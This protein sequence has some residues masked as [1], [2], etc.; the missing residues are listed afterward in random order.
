MCFSY[1]TEYKF[2]IIKGTKCLS[3]GQYPL[4]AKFEQFPPVHLGPSTFIVP[5]GTYFPHKVQAVRVIWALVKGYSEC[6]LTVTQESN[7][8]HFLFTISANADLCDIQ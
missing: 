1:C 3:F 7:L 5:R 2:D 8:Q 4:K 6:T